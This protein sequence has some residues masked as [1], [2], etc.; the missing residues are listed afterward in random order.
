ME[1]PPPFPQTSS[2]VF[3]A[4]TKKQF[5]NTAKLIREMKFDMAYISQYSPRPETAA[6]KMKD[7]VSRKE[8]TRREKVLTKILEKTALAKI[9]N[10]SEKLLKF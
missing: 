5:E 10:I 6:W 1:T 4:E 3:P 9:K 2:S 8:K 7:N